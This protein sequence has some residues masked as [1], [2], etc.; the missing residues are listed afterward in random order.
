MRV[1]FPLLFKTIISKK[2]EMETDARNQKFMVTGV[3]LFFFIFSSCFVRA[4]Y[5]FIFRMVSE[6]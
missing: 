2:N 4:I 1:L 6:R 3:G 5:F